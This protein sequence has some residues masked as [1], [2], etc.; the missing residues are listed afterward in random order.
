MNAKNKICPFCNEKIS[1]KKHLIQ[2]NPNIDEDNA[3]L[4]MIELTYNCQIYN[5]ILDY[6]SGYSLPD[7]KNKY[8]IS[9]K[10]TI[11]ILKIKRELIR[12]V[13]E[14]SNEKR[15]KK[16]VNTCNI[17]Y[18]V[19]NVSKLLKIKNKKKKTFLKNYG[20]DN[21]FKD[22]E[23]IDKM[24]SRINNMDDTDLRKHL[25]G[26]L[27][28]SSK[29]ELVVKEILDRNSIEYI[30]QKFINR[31][32]YDFQIKDTKILIE[33]HGDYW[34]ANPIKYKKN[35]LI[36]YPNNKKLIAEDVWKVDEIKKNNANKYGYV[37]IYVWE[38]DIINATKENR[39]EHFILNKIYE[40][41]QN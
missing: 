16:Y 15:L 24:K 29:P 41:I 35:D 38:S 9:Y 39:I 1:A 21:I 36:N 28:I 32:S 33:V 23:F 7:I 10:T 5:I 8:G 31:R 17:R 13:K 11:N 12:S 18:G 25:V 40:N 34:H 14:S 37:V 30:Q 26:I 3:Y 6:K 4:M 27:T 22:G 20:V 19:D 2:C